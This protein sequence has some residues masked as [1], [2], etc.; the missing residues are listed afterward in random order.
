MKRVFAA[1][2]AAV[3]LS[4]CGGSSSPQS[5]PQQFEQAQKPVSPKSVIAGRVIDA[6]TQGPLDGVSVRAV[7]LS[8]TTTAADGTFKI[9]NIVAGSTVTLVLEKMGYVRVLRGTTTPAAAGNS[10]LEGGLTT[11]NAELFPAACSVSGFVFLPNGR[12][13][14]GATVFV[15]QANAAVGESVVTGQTMTDGAFS[16]SGLGCRP[17]GTFHT[18]HAN[19]FDENGDMQADYAGV[20]QQVRLY[21]GQTARVFLTYSASSVGNRVIASNVI[22]GEVAATEEL[23]F[24]FALPLVTSS[25]D[26]DDRDQFVLTNLTRTTNVPVEGTFMSPTQLRVKPAN[27]SLREGERYQLS[28]SL[29]N[30]NTTAGTGSTYFA[31]FDFQVRPAVVMPFNVVVSGVTVLNPSP[32]APFGADKFNFD[33]N[34]FDVSFNP[35]AGAVRYEIF[36]RDQGNPNYVFLSSIDASSAPRLLRN[37]SLPNSF[38]T[39]PGFP[40]QPLAF[41][42]TVTFAVVAV[43]VYGNRSPFM[44]AMAVTVRDEIPPTLTGGPT[45]LADATGSTSIDGYNDTATPAVYRVRF[46]YSEPMDI[47]TAGAPTFTSAASAAP[48]AAWSWDPSDTLQRRA[49][50]TL[51]IPP[52]TDSTG[53]FIIRGG[54]DSSGNQVAQAGDIAGSIGGRRELLQNGNFQM[55]NSCSLTGWGPTNTNSTPVPVTVPNNGAIVGSTSPCAALLGSPPGTAP[56]TGRARITQDV[57]LP[58]TMMTGFSIE[59][60]ARTRPVFTLNRAALGAF[61]SM[62]CRVETVALPAMLIGSLGGFVSGGSDFTTAPYTLTGPVSLTGQGGNS[63]RVV[64]ES[65]NATTFAG[66]GAFYV[67]EISVALVRIGTLSP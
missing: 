58:T 21:P 46:S 49:I 4:A 50:L 34:S 12:P 13:A 61:Y 62:S 19:W 57:A 5:G 66:N 40:T 53:S 35:A 7:G 22:D 14:S 60:S 32:Q 63:V 24:T 52:N 9:E 39:I 25:F 29:R 30:A 16:L 59:A 28:L 36:A 3:G 10:P 65:D 64:C 20:N 6:A 48:M 45:V 18:V 1:M 44:T 56:S 17:S 37:V 26:Q 8:E 33:S 55:G 31:S 43:D 11:V 42:N 67:D 15:D 23:T 51:T 41:G 38:D 54:R 27:M 47:T 2:A